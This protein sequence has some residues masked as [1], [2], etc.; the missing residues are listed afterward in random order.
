MESYP[1]T[2]PALIEL[3]VLRTI[4]ANGP[5]HI[6][7][8]LKAAQKENISERGVRRVLSFFKSMNYIEYSRKNNDLMSITPTGTDYLRG[9]Q[10][11]RQ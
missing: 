11:G 8:V 10:D 5:V 2:T 9:I 1:T 4:A 7:E 6:W 3:V